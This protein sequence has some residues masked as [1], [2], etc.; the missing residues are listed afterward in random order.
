M[1]RVAVVVCYRLVDGKVLGT[2]SV[3]SVIDE[4]RFTYQTS[5]GTVKHG[6]TSQLAGPKASARVS[7]KAY[8][9]SWSKEEDVDDEY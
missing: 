8:V 3:L 1:K 5:D 6:R 4:V 7:G 2:G 9:A